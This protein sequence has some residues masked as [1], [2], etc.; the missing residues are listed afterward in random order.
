MTTEL[1][2]KLYNI[3]LESHLSSNGAE[4]TLPA[5]KELLRELR[6]ERFWEGKRP[7]RLPEEQMIRAWATYRQ[8]LRELRE[9]MRQRQQDW[10]VLLSFLTMFLIE[11]YADLARTSAI[12]KAEYQLAFD[13]NWANLTPEQALA[14]RDDWQAWAVEWL[15]DALRDEVEGRD[16][17]GGGSSG[18]AGGGD[19]DLTTEP[20]LK[21]K[22]ASDETGLE[23]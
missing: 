22:P 1:E 12:Y 20:G 11:H 6:T 8:D 15:R 9:R 14:C 16:G 19:G 4:K 3:L 2:D 18:G 21:P 5:L 17:G 23:Y 7:R 10:D 13:M